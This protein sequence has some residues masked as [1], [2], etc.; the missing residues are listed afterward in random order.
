MEH[1]SMNYN[2]IKGWMSNM[3][4]TS[5]N[6][7]IKLRENVLIRCLEKLRIGSKRLFDFPERLK[8]GKLTLKLMEN[9]RSSDNVSYG[10]AIVFDSS[11]TIMCVKENSSTNSSSI[12]CL[13]PQSDRSLKFVWIVD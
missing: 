4:K 12:F 11:V 8:V 3:N 1:S 2:K 13:S 9:L 10:G 7:K 5:R 6:K